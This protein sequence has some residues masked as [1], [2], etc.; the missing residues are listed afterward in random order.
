MIAVLVVGSLVAAAPTARAQTATAPDSAGDRNRAAEAGQLD[1]SRLPVALDR[2][3]RQLR[4]ATEREERRGLNLSYLLQVYAPAPSLVIFTPADGLTLDLAPR[5][6][7]S[8]AEMFTAVA[9]TAHRASTS[10]AFRRPAT[11]AKKK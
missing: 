2:V 8:H 3:Q 6:A 9:P 11:K 5:S 1:V 10:M 7:P 4:R